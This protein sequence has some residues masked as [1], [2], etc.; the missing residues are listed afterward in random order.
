M[1][2][3]APWPFGGRQKRKYKKREANLKLPGNTNVSIPKK[4]KKKTFINKYL[5]LGG[6]VGEGATYWRVNETL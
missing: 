5:T 3:N 4:R 2:E 1:P 6:G